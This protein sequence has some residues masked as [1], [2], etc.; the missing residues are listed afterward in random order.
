MEGPLREAKA[1]CDANGAE[2]LV[3]ALPLD[4]E[5][6]PSEWKKYAPSRRPRAAK[7]LVDDVVEGARRLAPWG[8]TPP[9]RSPPWSRAPSSSATSICRQRATAR[10]PRPSRRGSHRDR[11]PRR[12]AAS[13]P[14]TARASRPR[15]TSPTRARCPSKGSSAAGCETKLIREWFRVVCHEMDDR[16]PPTALVLERGGRGEAV[17]L[18]R[19]RRATLL[20]PILFGDELS[21][22]VSWGAFSQRLVAHTRAETGEL[23]MRF[24]G[25][26]PPVPGAA[27]PPGL[28]QACACYQKVRGAPTCAG[29]R[30][31]STRGLTRYAGDCDGWWRASRATRSARPAAARSGERGHDRPLQAPLGPG[32]PCATGPAPSGRE[33]AYASEAGPP[34]PRARAARRGGVR[35]VRIQRRRR[36]RALVVGAVSGPRSGGGARARRTA[37][38]AATAYARRCDIDT[39]PFFDEGASRGNLDLCPVDAA[40]AKRLGGDRAFVAYVA[41][42]RGS[43][44]ARGRSRRTSGSSASGSRWR[45][46]G[47]TRTGA[48]GYQKLA[49]AFNA[50]QLDQAVEPGSGARG[51][52]LRQSHL[53]PPHRQDHVQAALPVA[54]LRPPPLPAVRRL[55]H[56]TSAGQLGGAFGHAPHV[57]L[58][59]L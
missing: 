13:S 50:W 33:V 30:P 47:G 17:A 49:F 35:Q 1:I 57:T 14:R 38:A 19:D 27:P 12:R 25:K 7:V 16:G 11:F 6:D 32:W 22:V 48:R 51:R 21:A 52:V 23:E 36:A 53:A 15:A 26:A 37:M 10:S 29:S 9:L 43:S 56:R 34:S 45:C 2:L 20:V 58:G 46:A 4:V 39:C 41:A 59:A 55:T 40:A 54:S 3:V 44:R 8:S 18:V 31:S 24:E 28:D 42:H 5:V